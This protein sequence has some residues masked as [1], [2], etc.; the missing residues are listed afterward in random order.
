M[1]VRVALLAIMAAFTF[2]ALALFVNT[3]TEAGTIVNFTVNSSSDDHDAIPGDGI[4]DTEVG[5]PRICGMRAVL[6]EANALN[7]TN[8]V[9]FTA[10]NTKLATFAPGPPTVG[11]PLP[12]ITERIIIDA[13]TNPDGFSIDAGNIPSGEDGLVLALGSSGSTIMG[14]DIANAPGNALVI[15]GGAF[16]TIVGD[17]LA[18]GVRRGRGWARPARG[19]AASPS[20]A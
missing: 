6:E 15:C 4:C 7:G 12:E 3:T 20:G 9:D 14:L 10:A 13:S 16:H 18:G 11:G 2:G 8:S 19:K 17:P 1:A 5:E